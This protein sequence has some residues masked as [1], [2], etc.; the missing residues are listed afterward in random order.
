MKILVIN[1]PNMNMLGVREPA[2]YG[3]S[4]YRDLIILCENTARELGAD[5]IFFQSNHEGA[6]IDV[7]HKAFEDEIDG[8]VINPAGYSHTSVAILD[9]LKAVGIPT[10]EVHITEPQEREE[11]R[12]IDYISLAARETISGHG[13]AGYAEA[14]EKLIRELQ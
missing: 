5:C 10:I 4:T 12:R 11:F 14:I 1:G 3:S 9:A 2:L 6:I 13:L 8:I 7:I